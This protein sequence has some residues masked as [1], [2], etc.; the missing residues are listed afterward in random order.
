MKEGKNKEQIKEKRILD[1]GGKSEQANTAQQNWL[2][3][4]KQKSRFRKRKEGRILKLKPKKSE[5][6][7]IINNKNVK[8][9]SCDDFLDITK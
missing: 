2:K 6:N 1:D 8:K 7:Q 9:K 4:I 5:R 3:E